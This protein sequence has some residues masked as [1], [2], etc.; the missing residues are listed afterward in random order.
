[1]Y[2]DVLDDDDSTISRA[3]HD[4]AAAV[5]FSGRQD[6]DTGAETFLPNRADS[7]PSS[8][9]RSRSYTDSLAEA[10][11][12]G[13]PP[14]P[15]PAAA[16][17]RKSGVHNRPR[18]ASALTRPRP[19]SA[20]DGQMP[21]AEG[22]TSE[23]G[24][25]AARRL[26]S[27]ESAPSSAAAA[28]GETAVSTAGDQPAAAP[29]SSTGDKSGSDETG[30]GGGGGGGAR[31]RLNQRRAV[32]ERRYH[33]ADTIRDLDSGQ[34]PAIHK[35]LSLNYGGG[36]GGDVMLQPPGCSTAL[37][38]ESLGSFPSSSGVSSTASLYR[39]AGDD[40]DP[41]PASPLPPPPAADDSVAEPGGEEATAAA[42]T[43]SS[44][45]GLT[46]AQRLQLLVAE[47]RRLNQELLFMN[48]A[49]EAS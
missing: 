29:T 49:L 47:R 34:D 40:V 15:P 30:D 5:Q 44:D 48:P 41:A 20:A 37:S 32:R 17:L 26:R 13:P 16:A 33:T 46:A 28:A 11:I 4:A 43:S 3:V 36:V 14:P 25:A 2:D 24:R 23:G 1:L 22:L 27:C 12:M 6:S 7:S 45:T 39:A 31:P 19:P 21:T 10:A 18:S 35:R 38:S 42:Q 9:H 8:V